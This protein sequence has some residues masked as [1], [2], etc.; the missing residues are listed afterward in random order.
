MENQVINV[1]MNILM[2]EDD[3][4]DI[5]NVQR[6]FQRFH[7]ANPL[8]IAQNGISALA[9]LRNEILSNTGPIETDSRYHPTTKLTHCRRSHPWLILL[10]MNLPKMSGLEFLQALSQD[11]QLAILPVVILISSPSD[12]ARYAAINLDVMGYMMKPVQPDRLTEIIVAAN[13]YWDKLRS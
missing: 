7:I 5:M 10:D 12:Q 2:V 11:T 9:L 8:F 6:I 1:L 4:I 13:Q 3:Q